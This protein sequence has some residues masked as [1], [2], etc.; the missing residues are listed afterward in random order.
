MNEFYQ[1]STDELN[2]VPF[3]IETTGF[4]TEDMIT[5]IVLYND[6]AYHIWLNTDGDSDVDVAHIQ[7]QV[8]LESGLENVVMHVHVSEAEMVENLNAYI[9]GFVDREDSVIVAYNGEVYKGGFDLS[10]IR[11]RCFRTGT[12]FPFKGYW[13][14]DPYQV[15]AKQDL[16]NTTVQSEPSLEKM[17]KGDLI[18]FAEDLGI[19]IRHEKMYADEVEYKVLNNDGVSDDMIKEFADVK[20]LEILIQDEVSFD[21]F[22]NQHF[23]MFIDY[24]GLDIN[25]DGL[26]GDEI[27][28]RIYESPEFSEERLIEWH[29]TTGRDIGTRDLA[30]LDD[31]HKD[32]FEIESEESLNEKPFEVERFEPFDPYEESGEA[33]TGYMNQDYIGV[34]L[35]CLSDV[36]KTVNLTRNMIMYAPKSDYQPKTL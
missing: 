16:F 6:E 26:S 34:I 14:S 25:Y 33:V 31:I 11:T 8:V 23:K 19:D 4:T 28:Q 10:F 32:L 29:E 2:F 1:T 15:Y 17:K 27:A 3:D 30:T 21:N 7:D 18:S 22:K 35:H 12:Q 36:A 13:Y 20:D 9:D 5:N 24:F